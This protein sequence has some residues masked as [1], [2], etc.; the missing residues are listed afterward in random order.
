[1]MFNFKKAQKPI[2]KNLDVLF[3]ILLTIIT[4]ITVKSYNNNKKQTNAN[5]KNVLNN[6]YFQKTISHIFN[7]LTP[8]YKS[9]NHKI[10]NGE[11]FNELLMKYLISD[12]EIIKI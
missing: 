2:K 11:T 12:N 10:S 3:V 8:R 5:Y 4:I 6:I 9:V 7:N 1:M